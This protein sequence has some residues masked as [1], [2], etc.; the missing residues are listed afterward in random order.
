M[1]C[2]LVWL[3]ALMMSHPIVFIVEGVPIIAITGWQSPNI[4][5]LIFRW[6]LEWSCTAYWLQPLHLQQQSRV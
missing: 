1:K 5:K 2:E 4:I 6:V 3:V